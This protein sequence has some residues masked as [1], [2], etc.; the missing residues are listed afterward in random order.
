MTQKPKILAIVGPSSTGKSNLAVELAEKFGGEIISADSRYIY[1][2]VDI[3]AAKP[4]E[5][6]KR[7]IPHHLI[8]ICDVTED[9]SVGDFVKDADKLLKTI[10]KK[11]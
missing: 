2:Y 11:G 5:S 4:T 10:S 8:D 3:A 1:K 7:G 9:Y 6:E